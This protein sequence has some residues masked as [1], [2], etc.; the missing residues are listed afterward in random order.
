M[1]APSEGKVC[2]GCGFGVEAVKPCNKCGAYL[3][4][5]CAE[6]KYM[7]TRRLQ[8]CKRCNAP[9]ISRGCA[10]TENFNQQPLYDRRCPICGVIFPTTSADL[11]LSGSSEGWSVFTDEMKARFAALRAQDR[12]PLD[13][14]ILDCAQRALEILLT[15]VPG[16]N[17]P[18]LEAW[19]NSELYMNWP[20]THPPNL[21]TACAGRVTPGWKIGTS[22]CGILGKYALR[23]PFPPRGDLREVRLPRDDMET[24]AQTIFKILRSQLE[25]EPFTE[26]RQQ[27]L[28][29]ILRSQLDGPF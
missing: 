17:E 27:V 3:C 1:A 2:E 9:N 24:R 5:E 10:T 7:H 4:H 15:D 18:E 16:V 12:E 19:S 28:F 13:P 26:E 25:D 8:N 20:E 11:W 22:V 29:K 6:K 14:E 23:I 21:R